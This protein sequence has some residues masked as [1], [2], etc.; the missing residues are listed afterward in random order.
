MQR[1]FCGGLTIG[2]LDGFDEYQ[3]PR[4]SRGS[5][6][7]S[8]LNKMADLEVSCEWPTFPSDETLHEAFEIE[9]KTQNGDSVRFGELVAGKGDSIT[10][11]VIF[12]RHW[13]CTYDQ[14]YVRNLAGKIKERLLSTVP[15]NARPA[16]VIIIGCGDSDGIVP[17]IETTTDDF[18]IYSDPTGK[19]YDKLEM[20]RTTAFTDPPPYTEHSLRS[21]FMICMKQIWKRGMAGFRGGSWDQQGG[22]WIFVNGKLRYA[23]R[24]EAANDHLTAEQL[25]DILKTDEF[26]EGIEVV[27]PSSADVSAQNGGIQE[28]DIAV[29]SQND[30]QEAENL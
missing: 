8:L 20:K 21:S 4:V 9:I 17:Y 25:V 11:I 10:T 23:H 7:F 24:M 29:E 18:P 27:P 30:K 16:Q 2:K 12:V 14:D 1:L 3:I 28:S 26:R 6:Y 5:K 22:E 19:I 13:F 15:P